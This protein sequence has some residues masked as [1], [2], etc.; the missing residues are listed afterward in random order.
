MG[1]NIPH[2]KWDC[3]RLWAALCGL[4]LLP[5]NLLSSHPDHS[6]LGAPLSTQSAF[7]HAPNGSFS[8]STTTNKAQQSSDLRQHEWNANSLAILD[9][10][11]TTSLDHIR[12]TWTLSTIWSPFWSDR[13]DPL[14]TYSKGQGYYQRH[15]RRKHECFSRTGAVGV[16]SRFAHHFSSFPAA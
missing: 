2:P 9:P 4:I 10:Q 6:Q 13:L 12:V 14:R 7:Q 11:F 16:S 15:G 8:A 5:L 3:V 1:Y